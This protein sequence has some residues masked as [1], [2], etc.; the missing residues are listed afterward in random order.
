MDGGG[1]EGDL[2]SLFFDDIDNFQHYVLL[3]FVKV[4]TTNGVETKKIVFAK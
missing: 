3:Y 2:G 4:A 1:G